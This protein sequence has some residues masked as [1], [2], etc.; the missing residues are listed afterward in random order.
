MIAV[1]CNGT[2]GRRL[3]LSS[4]LFSSTISVTWGQGADAAEFTAGQLLVATSEMRDP[5]FAEA[6]IYMVKHNTEGA[7]GLVI[8]RPLAKGPVKDLL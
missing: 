5:R 6:V 7:M 4:L 8:N 3:A 2:W 1:V